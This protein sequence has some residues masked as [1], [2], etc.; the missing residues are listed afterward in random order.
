MISDRDILGRSPD[1]QIADAHSEY[2]I[3]PPDSEP[4]EDNEHCSI[5]ETGI[6]ACKK[7]PHVF[8][9]FIFYE[10]NNGKKKSILP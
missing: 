7:C 6:G 1:E 4:E 5:N 8:E 10:V 9:C 3:E 2:L